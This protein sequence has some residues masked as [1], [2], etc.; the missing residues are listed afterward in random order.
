M[1]TMT[2]GKGE[3]RGCTRMPLRWLAAPAVAFLLLLGTAPGA[4]RAGVLF[5]DNFDGGSPDPAWVEKNP[6]QWVQDGWF[7]TQNLGGTRDSMATAH[8]NNPAFTE[9]TFTITVDP[10][11]GQQWTSALIWFKTENMAMGAGLCEGRGYGLH[12]TN[13]ENGM[14]LNGPPNHLSLGRVECQADPNTVFLADVHYSL[15]TDPFELVIDVNAEGHIVISADGVTIID[16]VDPGVP[17][18]YGGIG[19][20]A[21]WEA[22]CRFDNISVVDDEDECPDDPNKTEP[23][24][25]GCGVPDT[26]T[27]EDG[28][29]DCN[30][31][32]PNDNLKTEPGICG[33]GV[34]D[35]DSDDD[36]TA[37]CIDSCPEDPNKTEPGECGCGE[38]EGTCGGGDPFPWDPVDCISSFPG[39]PS[40]ASHGWLFLLIVLG[41]AARAT[42]IF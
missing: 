37:D 33:C 10:V 19:I 21:I 23:G 40:N 29:Y 22:E 26:D 3:G 39:A 17:F 15:P 7:H 11:E 5:E 32:C 30:D 24:I 1:K 9:Y 27:D 36:G 18:P 35:A 8:E 42:R 34:I 20:G 31:E 41:L 4:A 6:G 38:E 12:I 2:L 13:S 28:T 14:I 25:C 16:V